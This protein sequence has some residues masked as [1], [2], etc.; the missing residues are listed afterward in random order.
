MRMF[1]DF[2]LAQSCE[3]CRLARKQP[4][5]PASAGPEIPKHWSA[6]MKIVTAAQM[7]EIDRRAAEEHAVPSLLLM[8]NAGLKT[9]AAI[10]RM[11]GDVDGRSVLIVSGKGNN[12]GDGFVVARHLFDRGANVTV[13]IAADPEEIKGDARINL[14]I[15]FKMGHPLPA[16]RGSRRPW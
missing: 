10:V 9:F 15:V 2:G 13:A 16:G 5:Q 4:M 12:G 1:R 14:E 7:R 11:L 8:E 6:S 3:R